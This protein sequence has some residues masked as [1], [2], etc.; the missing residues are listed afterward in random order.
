MTN[1]TSRRTALRS[2]GALG[3]AAGL[4]G[5]LS[6]APAMAATAYEVSLTEAQWKERLTPDQFDV[7][8]KAGTERPGSSPLNAEKRAGI[9]ECAGCELPV[10]SSKAKFESGTG[11]PSFYEPLSKDAVALEEDNT[12]FTKRTEVLCHRCGGH[13]GHVF[14]DG[15]KPTGKRYCMNGIALLFKPAAA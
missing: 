10:Y 6:R 2:L 3:A 5:W 9:F 11:W 4:G 14:D 1:R 13:L 8:R 12:F 7:L 15:P